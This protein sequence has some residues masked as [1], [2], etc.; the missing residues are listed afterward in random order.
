MNQYVI[1]LSYGPLRKVNTYNGYVVNGYK[2]HTDSYGSDR[3]TINSGVCIKGINYS[4]SES[5]YY[6]VL[7]EIIELEYLGLPLKRT[8]L[9]N[10]QWYH[11][12]PNV[13]TVV[14]PVYNI[15][16]VNTRR[17]YAKYEPFI[18][19]AQ[20]HQ[21]YFCTYPS[22]RR[23]KINWV[24]VCKVTARSDVDFLETSTSE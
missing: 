22:K 21:V 20:A 18:L 1:S 17:K 13:G 8:V 6:G 4:T 7:Q 24:A 5:D 2:F 10:C 14:H 12:T 3:A 23:D 15:I 9:F 19:A 11:P 16:D